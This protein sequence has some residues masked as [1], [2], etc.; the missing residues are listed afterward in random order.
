MAKK[1]EAI[2]AD[3]L[4]LIAESFPNNS[5]ALNAL[6][7]RP[8]V[9]IVANRPRID[10][11]R[12]VER[13]QK[14]KA[15]QITQAPVAADASHTMKLIASANV[16]IDHYNQRLRKE[17]KVQRLTKDDFAKQEVI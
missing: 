5:T 7:I 4:S 6:V 2:V 17:D 12:F 14:M 16:V 10:R 3:A 8:I 15:H 9:A 11:V 1:A 13:C